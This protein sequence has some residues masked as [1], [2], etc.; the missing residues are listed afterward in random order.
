MSCYKIFN[1][2]KKQLAQAK[3][4][5][6]NSNAILDVV[7]ALIATQINSIKLNNTPISETDYLKLNLCYAAQTLAKVMVKDEVMLL[8][9]IRGLFEDYIMSGLADCIHIV[10][11]HQPKYHQPN[12]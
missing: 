12:G 11:Y 10:V 1:G 5:E 4:G 2:I 8:P 3:L 9:A 6:Q 7:G